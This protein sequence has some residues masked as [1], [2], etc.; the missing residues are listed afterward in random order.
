MMIWIMYPVEVVHHGH[1]VI[2]VH[3]IPAMDAIDIC[4]ICFGKKTI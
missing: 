2:L 4:S 1:V 3:V